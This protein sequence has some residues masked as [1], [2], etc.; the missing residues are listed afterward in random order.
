[1]NERRAVQVLIHGRVQGVG[2]RAWTER[3]ARAHGL[4]GW[5]RNRH[6]GEVEALFAGEADA[7]ARM[8]EQCATGPRAA[9]VTKVEIL[10]EGVSAASGFHILADR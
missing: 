2:F 3:T 5:V 7:V 9:V 1:M 10:G 6:S 8:L 4:D